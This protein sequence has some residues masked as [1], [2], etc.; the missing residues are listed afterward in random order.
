MCARVI[1]CILTLIRIF[2]SLILLL[3]YTA[4]VCLVYTRR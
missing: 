3:L 1:V 2:C 4:L